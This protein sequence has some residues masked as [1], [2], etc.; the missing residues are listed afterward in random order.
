MKN[1]NKTSMVKAK[2]PSEITG[3]GSPGPGPMYRL[4]L[5]LIDPDLMLKGNF[6]IF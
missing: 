5:P 6:A 4:N 1:Q 3:L 2:G